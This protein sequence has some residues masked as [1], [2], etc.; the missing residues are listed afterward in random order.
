MPELYKLTDN[1]SVNIFVTISSDI[2]R[3]LLQAI[4]DG[5]L[6]EINKII[7]I[8]QFSKEQNL[9]LSSKYKPLSLNF[10]TT[11]ISVKF[12]GTLSSGDAKEINNMSLIDF[13]IWSSKSDSPEVL[14][15]LVQQGS[16]DLLHRRALIEGFHCKSYDQ[17]TP[18]HS[19]VLNNKPKQLAY[20]LRMFLCNDFSD[21]LNHYAVRSG[22]CSAGSSPISNKTLTELAAKKSQTIRD[23]VT[24]AQKFETA[25]VYFGQNDLCEASE[26][27]MSAF[28]LNSELIAEILT[29]FYLKINPF[30]SQSDEICDTNQKPNKQEIESASLKFIKYLDFFIDQ[31]P[32]LNAQMWHNETYGHLKNILSHHYYRLAIKQPKDAIMLLANSIKSD[33]SYL[34][35]LI[36]H[37]LQ[38]SLAQQGNEDNTDYHYL[39]EFIRHLDLLRK[40]TK[41][42]IEDKI[43]PALLACQVQEPRQEAITGAKKSEINPIPNKPDLVLFKND[44]Q[45]DQFIKSLSIKSEFYAEASQRFGLFLTPSANRNTFSPSPSPSPSL[46]LSPDANQ[47]ASKSVNFELHK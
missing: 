12:E 43:I 40:L 9:T 14:E 25:R 21:S 11:A 45:R 37:D 24:A 41:E 31:L 16:V 39:L 22:P 3:N 47:S 34:I 17:I 33:K 28:S 2:E 46:S 32:G 18:I 23:L 6:N 5:D 4:C 30:V 42:D 29:D 44:E 27:F 19:A 26:Y 15:I 38:K 35:D 36:E 8:A 1:I 20:L 7:K 10:T 13:A